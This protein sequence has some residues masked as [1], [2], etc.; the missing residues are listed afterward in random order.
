MLKPKNIERCQF[1]Q[2]VYGM[3]KIFLNVILSYSLHCYQKIDVRGHSSGNLIDFIRLNKNWIRGKYFGGERRPKSLK[4]NLWF[5][6]K[7]LEWMI[8]QNYCK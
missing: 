2:W 1:F 8:L 4:K 6:Y 3:R 7:A 5:N